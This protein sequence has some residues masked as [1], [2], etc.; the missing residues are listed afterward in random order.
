[1]AFIHVKALFV[2]ADGIFMSWRDGVDVILH[3]LKSDI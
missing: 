1:M 2:P 3:L